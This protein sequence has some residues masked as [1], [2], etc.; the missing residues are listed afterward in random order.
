MKD[1]LG[2]DTWVAEPV[3]PIL[4][5]GSSDDLRVMGSNPV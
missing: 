4:V 2:R 3:E 5:I 1:N